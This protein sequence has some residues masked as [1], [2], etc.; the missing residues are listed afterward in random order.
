[1]SEMLICGVESHLGGWS[2]WLPR[3]R[4]RAGGGE[5][6]S[7]VWATRAAARSFQPEEERGALPQRG[8]PLP[9]SFL[10]ATSASH[11]ACALLAPPLILKL[12]K[13]T[14]FAQGKTGKGAWLLAR[15]GAGLVWPAQPRGSTSVCIA[16]GPLAP[17]VG[18]N[19][20]A[21]SGH[22]FR[23]PNGFFCFFILP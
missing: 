18:P 23:K 4:S 8:G 20:A 19:T 16:C 14:D 10:V 22:A 15:L 17:P 5:G 2:R 11:C 6:R 21:P 12:L 1:M 9:S 7:L 13:G 3:D